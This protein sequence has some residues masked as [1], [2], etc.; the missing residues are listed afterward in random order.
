MVLLQCA[1]ADGGWGVPGSTWEEEEE[2]EKEEKEVVE[3][4]NILCLQACSSAHEQRKKE[5]SQEA[6]AG[7]LD[8]RAGRARFFHREEAQE[9]LATTLG[10]KTEELETRVKVKLN[11]KKNT[12]R[13]RSNTA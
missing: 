12:R 1:R 6:A 9:E 8:F 7:W 3:T 5:S 11:K 4:G 2:E 10:S 13:R